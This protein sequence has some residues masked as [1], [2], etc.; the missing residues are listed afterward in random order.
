V[1]PPL[2]D[3][4]VPVRGHRRLEA[5]LESAPADMSAAVHA[6]NVIVRSAIERHGRYVFATA[7]DGFCAAFSSA[8]DAVMAAVDSQRPLEVD[9]AIPFAGRM[10]LHTGKA[11]ERTLGCHEH[12]CVRLRCPSDGKIVLR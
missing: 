12:E 2:G 4:D 3:G 8:G 5:P 1:Q 10:D 9:D 7:G 6:H 11:I